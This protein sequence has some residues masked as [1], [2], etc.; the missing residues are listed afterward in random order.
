MRSSHPAQ[1]PL[2][3]AESTRMI[4]GQTDRDGW[5][6]LSRGRDGVATATWDINDGAPT[7][8]PTMASTAAIRAVVP[9]WSTQGLIVVQIANADGDEDVSVVFQP[10]ANRN[11]PGSAQKIEYQRMRA[12]RN[13][14]D[15]QIL[16]VATYIIQWLGGH[17]L[18]S[19]RSGMDADSINIRAL[20]YR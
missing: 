13:T 3:F 14:P 18:Y 16:I 6:W 17:F 2:F 1:H 5:T 8:H 7:N 15:T 4:A 20:A 11:M 10:D 12:E 9:P 19:T